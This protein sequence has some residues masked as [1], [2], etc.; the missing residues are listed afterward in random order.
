LRKARVGERPVEG[1]LGLIIGF[2]DFGRG[3]F[4]CQQLLARAAVIEQIVIG[5][6]HGVQGGNALFPGI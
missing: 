2:L 6:I 1:G 4:L 3:P 5:A